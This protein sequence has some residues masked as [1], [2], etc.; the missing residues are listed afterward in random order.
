MDNKFISV[1]VGDLAKVEEISIVDEETYKKEAED[2]KFKKRYA[3]S[4]TMGDMDPDY[5]N[6]YAV[7]EEG[8]VG[9]L[10]ILFIVRRANP[11][12]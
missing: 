10:D 8:D 11:V 2:R 6:W 4:T 1:K 7:L 5:L 9:G 12:T 3:V